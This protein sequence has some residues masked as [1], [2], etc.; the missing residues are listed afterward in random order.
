MENNS[1]IEMLH[2]AVTGSNQADT[3]LAAAMKS[4]VNQKYV[5]PS[6]KPDPIE[7]TTKWLEET[8]DERKVFIPFKYWY[9]PALDQV[10]FKAHRDEF[11]VR[12][13]T[14]GI[15]VK[16]ADMKTLLKHSAEKLYTPEYLANK[17]KDI[18][19][20][21][22]YGLGGVR[23]I[24]SYL[25]RRDKGDNFIVDVLCD[26]TS[27]KIMTRHPVEMMQ[28]DNYL[29]FSSMMLTARELN[30][31][32]KMDK[33]R[34]PINIPACVKKYNMVPIVLVGNRRG[35]CANKKF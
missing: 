23:S 24:D 26:P 13:A 10:W 34:T 5:S 25:L 33:S 17:Q 4:V 22:K 16:L 18:D 6:Y 15:I 14:G 9:S 12:F 28:L 3:A 31:L 11:Q 30:S 7:D 27:G 2:Q 32:C 29:L 1:L 19:T 20:C 35:E 21:C 8:F